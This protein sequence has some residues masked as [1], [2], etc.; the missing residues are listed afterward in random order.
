VE[1]KVSSGAKDF[2][3]ERGFD[4]NLGARPLK[5]VIQKMVL[6]PLALKIVRGEVQEGENIMVDVEH[7]KIV[8]KS[9]RDL[10]GKIGKQK[11][12]E[13]LLAK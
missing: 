3:A 4:R 10:V 1:I 7:N 8:F 2:L 13:K 9:T 6:D 11:K 12:P 5:R